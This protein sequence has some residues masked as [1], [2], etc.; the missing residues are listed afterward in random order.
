[1]LNVDISGNSNGHI[2]E[3]RDATVTWLGKL[4]VLHVL[5]MLMWP[6]PGRRSSSWGFWSSDN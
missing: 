2:S 3:L 1:L 5:G 6:W 4:V